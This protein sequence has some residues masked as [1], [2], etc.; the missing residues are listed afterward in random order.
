MNT[1]KSLGIITGLIFIGISIYLSFEFIE[2]NKNFVGRFGV[3]W[4]FST[5]LLRLLVCFSFGR[6][7]QLILKALLPKLKGAFSFIIG[8]II[9]F[10]VSF[11]SPIYAVDYGDY[12]DNEISLNTSD[13]NEITQNQ[14]SSETAPYLVCFFTTT[15]PHCKAACQLLGFMHAAGRM[16]KVV[17]IFPGEVA[18]R[19]KFVAENDGLAFDAYSV[20]DKFFIENSGGVFPSIFLVN[21]DGSMN[22]HWYGGGLN[23]TALDYLAT[24]K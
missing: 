7:L 8:F 23:Y 13:F 4:V 14:Y 18:N 12:S 1:Q 10:G 15:C 17:L 11:I 16:T 9:G 2:I 24:F 5:I 19:E 3:G 20:S 22:K 21:P 6:G